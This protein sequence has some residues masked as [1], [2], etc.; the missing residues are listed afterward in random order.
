MYPRNGQGNFLEIWAGGFEGATLQER[1]QQEVPKAVVNIFGAPPVEGLGDGL[2]LGAELSAQAL[3][4]QTIT[5]RFQPGRAG[6]VRRKLQ[7]RT[8]LQNAT[9]PLTIEGNVTP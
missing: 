8:D 2:S 4:V 5:L 7:I 6:E 1:L 9:I 3:P